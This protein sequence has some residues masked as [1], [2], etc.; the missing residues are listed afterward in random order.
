MLRICPSTLFVHLFCLHADSPSLRGLPLAQTGHRAV[1]LL[2]NSLPKGWRVVAIERN[3]HFN[4]LYA[5][6]RVSV[7][8]GHE[9]KPFIPYTNIFRDPSPSDVLLPSNSQVIDRPP[10]SFVHATV[11]RLEAHRVF[12]R[13]LDNSDEPESCVTTE[14]SIEFNYC[15]YALGSSLPDPI[16]I[17]SSLKSSTAGV[18]RGLKSEGCAWLRAEQARIAAAGS[19]CIIGGGALGVQYASDIADIFPGQKRVTLIHSRPQLLPLFT[20]D[21]GENWMHNH[22]SRS[23]RDLGVDLILGARVDLTGVNPGVMDKNRLITV[24]VAATGARCTLIC[25]GQK[26]NTRILAQLAPDS[27]VVGPAEPTFSPYPHIFVVGDSADAFGAMKAGHTAWSQ[28]G[29]ACHNILKLISAEESAD[30][31]AVELEEYQTQPPQI[32]VS[33]GLTHAIY[34]TLSGCG[35]QGAHE[36]DPCLN[37]HLM[38]T[39]RGLSNEDMT[40]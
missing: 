9:Y 33:L 21:D 37:T 4:H 32:K 36:C 17:W 23:L 29:L 38:W 31:D 40:V 5:F 3:T 27:D 16:N 24:T 20:S 19:I 28:A 22:A 8:P 7:L 34:Q 10:H 14:E 35:H 6:C 1:N 39:R 13:R 26:P 12:F 18:Q 2:A 11:T 30:V 15:I 25:T